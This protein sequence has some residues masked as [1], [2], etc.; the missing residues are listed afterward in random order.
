MSNHAGGSIGRFSRAGSSTP[1][2]HWPRGTSPVRITSTPHAPPPDQEQL[3]PEAQAHA[4]VVKAVMASVPHDLLDAAKTGHARAVWTLLLRL[5]GAAQQRGASPR[6]RS[7]HGLRSRSG[8][9]RL[10]AA[11][12]CSAT[13]DLSRAVIGVPGFITVQCR[14]ADGGL[15]HTS[16][17]PS[18][19]PSSSLSPDSDGDDHDPAAFDHWTE[20]EEGWRGTGSSIG[21]SPRHRGGGGG[22]GGT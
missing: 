20:D 13:G 6:R 11:R 17:A 2:S 19:A 5:R 12:G 8:D 15:C 10:L 16:P 9:A 4:A 22:G 7:G 21:S 1:P 18:F 3:T 14:Y